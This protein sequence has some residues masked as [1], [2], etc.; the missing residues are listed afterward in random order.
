MTIDSPSVND[1][2]F[3]LQW[4]GKSKCKR[5]VN[6]PTQCALQPMSDESVDFA[7]S[8]NVII[9]GDNLDV[10]KLLR[11]THA[12]KIDMI[13]IDP[14]YNTGNE[15]VYR[16]KFS[17]GVL[18]YLRG[19]DQALGEV[20]RQ[21]D[22]TE[23]EGRFH[24]EWLNMMYPRLALARDLLTPSG[25]M[26]I[27]IDDHEIEHLLCVAKEIFGSENVETMVWNKE[28]E[29]SSGTLKS[30]R[31]FRRVHEYVV[32][33][34]RNSSRVEWSRVAEALPGREGEFQTANLAVNAKNERDDHPNCFP[35]TNPSGDVFTRQWK[36]N[37]EEI[38]RLISH[39][40]IYWG[41]DG[42]KQPRLIIPTDERRTTYL[43][44]I[45]N[46]GGT[47]TGRKDFESVMKGEATFSFP[48]PVVLLEKLIASAMPKTG[49]VLDFFAGSGTTGHAVIA[50]NA[51]DGG[52]RNYILVQ[53]PE[54]TEGNFKTIAAIARER[55]RR[56]GKRVAEMENAP[57]DLGFRAYRVCENP[58][59]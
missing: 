22:D 50:Q 44:S 46:Y 26:F 7:K 40:L 45:L 55:M 27:S 16:D 39:D 13:Y 3:G 4:R 17:T 52:N 43:R 37:R 56:V 9:E 2:R 34:Y 33:C 53:L 6:E 10:L 18:E 15:F 57:V 38:E 12:E 29:G 49:T 31:T 47:T 42:R 35:V 25:A 59:Q 5:V 19:T 36:W 28:A 20:S 24:A 23:T 11:E 30:V 54:P 1:E 48:K 58:T 41:S 8:E 21:M 32:V 51:K 14:P